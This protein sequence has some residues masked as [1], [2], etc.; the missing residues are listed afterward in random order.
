MLN[1]HDECIKQRRMKESFSI[2][3]VSI[4]CISKKK[5]TTNLHSNRIS[6][7]T[8]MKNSFSME[9]G[10][11]LLLPIS[12]RMKYLN[13]QKYGLCFA[14]LPQQQPDMEPLPGDAQPPEPQEKQAHVLLDKEEAQN[15]IQRQFL[16]C[17]ASW[18]FYTPSTHAFYLNKGCPSS[19]MRIHRER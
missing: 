17:S 12:F 5:Y 6:F 18:S 2:E 4:T 13:F 3:F 10:V 9:Y 7:T 14:P 15:M 11:W 1:T 16:H 8:V 19:Q